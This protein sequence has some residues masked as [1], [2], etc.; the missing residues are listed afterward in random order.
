[1]V[2]ISAEM[3]TTC[4]SSHG[5]EIM[6]RRPGSEVWILSG[7]STPTTPMPAAGNCSLLFRVFVQCRAN[8]P[9]TGTG[10][11]YEYLQTGQRVVSSSLKPSSK[12]RAVHE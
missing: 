4:D 11:Q 1:M 3:D 8:L 2:Y 10:P 12:A 7:E 5:E 9:Q 6:S